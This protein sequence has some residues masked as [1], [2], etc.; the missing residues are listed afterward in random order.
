MKYYLMGIYYQ[1]EVYQKRIL[2]VTNIP[3]DFAY[4]Q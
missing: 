4:R 1:K 2:C 3:N